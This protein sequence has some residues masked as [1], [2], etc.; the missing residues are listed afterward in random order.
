MHIAIHSHPDDGHHHQLPHQ[1][2]WFLLMLTLMLMLLS[3]FVAADR[4]LL[5]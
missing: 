2:T 5:G 4:L 1:A 3:T